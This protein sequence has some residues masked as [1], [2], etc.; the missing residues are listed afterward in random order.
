M[1]KQPP[2]RSEHNAASPQFC[3]SS[4]LV[5]ACPEFKKRSWLP[6]WRQR[7]LRPQGADLRLA[8]APDPLCGG[9]YGHTAEF[10]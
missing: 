7:G 4:A 9:N 5:A 8:T 3:E 6:S 1:T 2:P 10:S